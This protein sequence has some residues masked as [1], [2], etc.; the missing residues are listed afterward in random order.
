[1]NTMDTIIYFKI[2]MKSQHINMDS[3]N[4]KQKHNLLICVVDY[5]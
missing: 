5:P 3:Y 1:M 4:I 2:F